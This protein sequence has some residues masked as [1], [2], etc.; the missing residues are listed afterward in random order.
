MK[1]NTYNMNQQSNSG[2]CAD[3]ILDRVTDLLLGCEIKDD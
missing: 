3:Y 1:G 2:F